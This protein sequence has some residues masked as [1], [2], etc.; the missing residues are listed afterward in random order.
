MKSAG[1][2]EHFKAR[3]KIKMICV[4]E[5][6]LCLDILLKISVV[7]TLDRTD[8]TYRHEYRSFDLTMV[9]RDYAATR[10]GLRVVMC[11]YEFH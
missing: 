8:C 10:S 4:S 5:D 9:S 7:Y 3:A 1:R 6:D 11:L 2:L